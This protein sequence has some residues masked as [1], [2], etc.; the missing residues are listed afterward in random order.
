MMSVE[1]RTIY[2]NS[3]FCILMKIVNIRAPVKD[4]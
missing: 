3:L 1:C 2:I 4:D